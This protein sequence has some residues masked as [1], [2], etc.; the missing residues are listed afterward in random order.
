[1]LGAAA[2]AVVFLALRGLVGASGGPRHSAPPFDVIQRWMSG[3][4]K[5]NVRDAVDTFYWEKG[6]LPGEL[7]ELIQDGIVKPGDMTFPWGEPYLY[8]TYASGVEEGFFVFEP[9]R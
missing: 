6:R 8:E 7:N 3:L 5:L 1:M 2:V 4:Q 9:M